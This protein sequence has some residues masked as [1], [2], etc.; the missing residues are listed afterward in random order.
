MAE[1]ESQLPPA[2]E[3][4]G[5]LGAGGFGEVVLARHRTIGRLVAVK[6]IHE[7]ALADTEAIDRFRRE[8][9]VLASTNCRSVVHV[10]DLQV[11]EKGAQLVMEYV[12][13][14]SLA[15]L[16]ELGPLSAG[17]GLT[18]LKD[19]ADALA[20]MAEQGIIHRDVKPGNV[21]V[22][23]DGH[24]K[25]GDFGLAR[26]LTDPSA[27]RTAGGPAMGTPA[28]FPPE[29]SQGISEPDARS[30]A[31]SFAVMTYEV[32]TG[33]RP[34]DA[35]DALSLITA[36]WHNDPKPAVEVLPGFPDAAWRILREG[37]HKD[38]SKRLLPV[39][40]VSRLEAVPVAAWP[41][42]H[43]RE[44]PLRRSDPTLRQMS[45]TPG[46]R[47]PGR[48][49][50]VVSPTQGRRRRTPLWATAAL[51]S[52]AVAAMGVVLV[53]RHPQETPQRLEVR[54]VRVDVDPR[55][56]TATCPRGRFVFTATVLTN[57]SPGTLRLQWV[58]PDGDTTAP[59]EVTV[60]GGQTQ[61]RAELP[62]TV[63]GPKPLVG[64]A[65]LRVLGAPHVSARRAVRYTCPT[66]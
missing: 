54:T 62:F 41:Q 10:Y 24:A 40:L 51:V 64:A 48:G 19:V 1:Q 28:Y 56:G 14:Q 43:R 15:E 63:R 60:E 32:L 37:L 13:G 3:F 42:V 61:I 18:L 30:D 6:R 57:G 26:A 45:F 55:S 12:P 9:R 49:V 23:P 22:L 35:P 27:F 44:A 46:G 17:D 59:R 11:D 4:V 20:T 58:Q 66:S 21:F 65:E 36:H 7:H 31:Y 33:G 29:V 47:P 50:R 52:A 2:Y 38:P 8:A 53:L 39:V 34:F 25:L 16:L 5:P